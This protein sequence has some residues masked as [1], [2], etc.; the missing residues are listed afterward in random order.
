MGPRASA[1][2]GIAVVHHELP[3]RVAVQLARQSLESAKRAGRDLLEIALC[4]RSGDSH[5]AFCPW[6]SAKAVGRW[7]QVFAAGASD[8]WARALAADLQALAALPQ[9]AIEAELA[10]LVNRSD[11]QTRAA[12]AGPDG[13]DAGSAAATELRN[14]IQQLDPARRGLPLLE[15][16][17]QFCRLV[18]TAAVLARP[19]RQV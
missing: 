18:L 19:E 10:R 16:I 17:G 4:S 9:P 8:R 12:L 6:Q 2:A 1:S 13:A 3:L 5:A 14:Y 15:A 7:L 11:G